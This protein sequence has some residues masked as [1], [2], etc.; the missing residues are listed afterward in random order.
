MIDAETCS[1]ADP[2]S[3]H[4]SGVRIP[5]ARASPAPKRSAR[6]HSAITMRDVVD[7]DEYDRWRA[8]AQGALEAARR[9]AGA[10]AHNWA[11]FL[12]EQSAQLAVKALLH[13]L[14]LGPWGHDL[15]ELG[16]TARDVAGAPWPGGLDQALLRLS[17]HY[18]PARYPDAHAGGPARE[19]YGPSDSE[20]ALSD[21]ELT[22][23]QIDR[24][25]A[26]L[27]AEASGEG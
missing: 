14:A 17:R 26:A 22:I 27:R 13:A 3:R 21:A 9:E 18:I 20:Q 11:C 4:R 10:G 23:A 8:D 2:L 6:P 5:A 7:S 24:L 15:V 16:S 25:W 1:L 12:A 19:R